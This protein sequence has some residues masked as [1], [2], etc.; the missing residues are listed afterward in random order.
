VSSLET[1]LENEGNHHEGN[2]EEMST[3]EIAIA[4]VPSKSATDMTDIDILAQHYPHSTPMERKRFMVGRKLE[5]GMEKMNLYMEWREKYQL[6]D[7]TFRK[8]N[9]SFRTDKDVWDWAVNYAAKHYQGDSLKLD[10]NLKEPGTL[11]RI[12]RFGDVT[13]LKALDGRRLVQVLPG[14]LDKTVAPQDFYSLCVAI[15]LDLKLDRESNET[16]HVFV[17]LRAGKNWPN[18]A[19]TVLAPFVKDLTNQLADNMPERMIS[20]IVY[21][22]PSLA[23]PIWALFKGFIPSKIVNKIK[24]LWGPSGVKSPIPKTMMKDGI[25]DE[26]TLEQ[27]EKYRV[28]EFL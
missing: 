6:D 26:Y 15:Y 14:M 16:I 10:L 18:A 17:D 22:V 5:R 8:P 1:S 24:V 25:L 9:Q 4:P 12:V 19:P 11:P 27:I 7:S 23:K 2:H 3:K 28:A 13:D 20:T 21:P